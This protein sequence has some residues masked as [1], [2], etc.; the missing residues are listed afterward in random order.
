MRRSPDIVRGGL[1]EVFFGRDPVAAK[2][3]RSWNQLRSDGIERGEAALEGLLV[4]LLRHEC[5]DAS[6]IA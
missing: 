4:N 6:P 5:I 3:D 2:L 1:G